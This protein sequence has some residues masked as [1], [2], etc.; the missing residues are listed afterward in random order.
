MDYALT[1]YIRI[2]FE[3]NPAQ[4]LPLHLSLLYGMRQKLEK[5]GDLIKHN[6]NLCLV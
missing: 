5:V 3:F 1:V 6:G 2:E 4:V